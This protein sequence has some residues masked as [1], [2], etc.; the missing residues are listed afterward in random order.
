MRSKK[1]E[2]SDNSSQF[3]TFLADLGLPSGPSRP[4]DP[5]SNQKM[6]KRTYRCCKI[7]GPAKPGVAGKS[8]SG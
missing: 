6:A 2:N 5:S 8:L 4:L 3:I 7:R 1:N